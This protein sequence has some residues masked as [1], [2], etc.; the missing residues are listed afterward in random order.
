M[1]LCFIFVVK[2]ARLG[3]E[4]VTLSAMATLKCDNYAKLVRLLMCD[5]LY[6][7]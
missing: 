6:A 7:A 2:Y 4:M 3:G 5:V 1:S